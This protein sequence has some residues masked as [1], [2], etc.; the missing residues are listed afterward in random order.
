LFAPQPRRQ[1]TVGLVDFYRHANA[2]FSYDTHRNPRRVLTKPGVGASNNNWDNADGDYI[3]IVND[4][5][6]AE[7]GHQYV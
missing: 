3:L 7:E 6:G 4:I 2:N 5:I 1:S